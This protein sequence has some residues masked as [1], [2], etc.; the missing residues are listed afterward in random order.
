[1]SSFGRPSGRLPIK[2]TGLPCHPPH[3]Y[4]FIIGC[5]IH[6]ISTVLNPPQARDKPSEAD[7]ASLRK[8]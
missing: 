2:L 5:V 6:D 1:M 7:E 3:C 4:V 8:I